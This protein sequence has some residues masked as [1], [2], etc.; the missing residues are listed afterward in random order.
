MLAEDIHASET[1]NFSTHAHKAIKESCLRERKVK[2]VKVCYTREP[3]PRGTASGPLTFKSLWSRQGLPGGSPLAWEIDCLSGR[4]CCS[5]SLWFLTVNT[6]WEITQVRSSGQ[7]HRGLVADVLPQP[8]QCL[9]LPPLTK[10]WTG[11]QRR[12]GRW[13]RWD[14]VTRSNKL[15]TGRYYYQ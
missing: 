10:H 13:W 7:G 1:K 15:K 3:T 6:T 9:H 4:W 8:L 11:W 14:L 5:L 2:R 12:R